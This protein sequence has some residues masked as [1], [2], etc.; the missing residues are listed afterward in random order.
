MI[1]YEGEIVINRPVAEVFDYATTP[2]N[3][4]QWTDVTSM[5]RL[6]DGPSA[7]GT[8]LQL[9]MGRG[10]M[11]SRNDFE[12]VRWEQDRNWTF[13]TVSASPIVWDG[14]LGFEPQGPD[15][16]L[17]RSSG[18]VTLR[19]WRKLLEPVARGELRKREQAELETLRRLLES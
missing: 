12:T 16:T 15:S 11:K 7:V 10:P 19:G 13:R 1:T 5:K 4:P 18:Q 6:S 17:V 3:F 8:R 9:E 2:A 14:M